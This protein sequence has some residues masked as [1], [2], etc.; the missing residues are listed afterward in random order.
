M[1]DPMYYETEAQILINGFHANI[2]HSKML[3]MKNKTL[4]F[5]LQ[6]HT[7]AF[8]KLFNL[9]FKLLNQL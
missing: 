9:F 8:F 6:I 3:K 1:L 7:A 4:N 2:F 5:I